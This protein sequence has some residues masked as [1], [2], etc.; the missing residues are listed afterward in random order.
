MQQHVCQICFF[1]GKTYETFSHILKK[2]ENTDE[3]KL[4][5]KDKKT[6]SKKHQNNIKTQGNYPF[7]KDNK[8]YKYNSKKN[9][10]EVYIPTKDDVIKDEFLSILTFN[11]LFDL[12]DKDKIFT[13][14]RTSYI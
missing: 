6:F 9:D 4:T 14:D 8:Q 2:H 13:T 11:I 3:N 10:W 12:Y 1:S 7:I 5:T